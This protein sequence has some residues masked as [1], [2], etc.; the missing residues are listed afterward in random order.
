MKKIIFA[1]CLL[2]SF[3]QINAQGL[4]DIKD[5]LKE[6]NIKDAKV[7]MDAWMTK[8]NNETKSENW[9]Y[10]GMI[11]NASSKEKDAATLC[12][13]C[14]QD[15]FESF[16][17]YMSIDTKQFL[18]K[19]SENVHFFDLYNGFLDLGNTAYEA[20]DLETAYTRFNQANAVREYI[21]EK[22]L[23][24]KDTKFTGVDTS[25]LTNI[26]I[27]AINIK[28][29]TAAIDVYTKLMS[30]NAAPQDLAT[31]CAIVA[32]N[33]YEAGNKTEG[34]A[35]NEQCKSYFTNNDI[36]FETE[37][38]LMD[39]TDKKTLFEKYEKAI[40]AK[41]NAYKLH[42]NYLVELFNVLHIDNKGTEEEKE[43]L[44]KKVI[45]IANKTMSINSNVDVNAML[46]KHYYNAVYDMQEKIK[47][48]TGLPKDVIAKKNAMKEKQSLMMDDCIT[49]GLEAEKKY[50]SIPAPTAADQ[51]NLKGMYE[52]LRSIYT[53]KALPLK[54]AEYKAKYDGIK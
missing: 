39:N 11:E 1:L 38:Q 51:Q 18:M 46:A 4:D 30:T 50:A 42:F 8:Q 48:V 47:K 33:A 23:I 17:K 41:P 15:A 36:F 22:K 53:L 14:K 10:K 28:K 40:A 54:V 9:Y 19:G 27:F 7:A 16:K 49:N 31:N 6:N 44:T 52:V 35:F 25:L 2:S 34:A 43:I 12:K 26:A 45:A 21:V 3:T 20:K 32:V 13:D 29:Y 24:Y 37:M 5:L